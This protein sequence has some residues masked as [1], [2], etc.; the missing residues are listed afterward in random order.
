[1]VLIN[2]RLDI[3]SVHTYFTLYW[4]IWQRYIDFNQ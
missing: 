4:R 1:V 2:R 3:V